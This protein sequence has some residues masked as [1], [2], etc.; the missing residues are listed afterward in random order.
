MYAEDIFSVDKENKEDI[1]SVYTEEISSVYTGN[2][3]SANAE[4]IS[5]VHT[6]DISSVYTADLS[7]DYTEDIIHWADGT[8]KYYEKMKE[9]GLGLRANGLETLI[10]GIKSA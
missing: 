2:T 7:S 5:S 1:S 10:L 4:D 8:L 6:E 9:L 3:S